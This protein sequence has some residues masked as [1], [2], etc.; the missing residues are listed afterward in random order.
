M[1]D[2][3]VRVEA[4][5]LSLVKPLVE[6][7]K[8]QA[9]KDLHDEL[10]DLLEKTR[11]VLVRTDYLEPFHE[12]FPLSRTQMSEVRVSP[13]RSVGSVS[14]TNDLSVVPSE[15]EVALDR[16]DVSSCDVLFEEEMIPAPTPQ[17]YRPPPIPSFDSTKLL[18]VEENWPEA[19][20]AMDDVDMMSTWQT[21]VELELHEAKEIEVDL[22][23]CEDEIV[24]QPSGKVYR[25]PPNWPEERTTSPVAFDECMLELKDLET[26]ALLQ[27]EVDGAVLEKAVAVEE[28]IYMVEEE[29]F[30]VEARVDLRQWMKT[31]T[32]AEERWISSFYDENVLLKPIQSDV[33]RLTLEPQDHVESPLSHAKVEEC[34]LYYY[35]EESYCVDVVCDVRQLLQQTQL[36]EHSS[37]QFS[38]E[39][40]HFPE[41]VLAKPEW[42]V[43]E[44]GAQPS[45]IK[46]TQVDIAAK[47]R[48]SE[49]LVLPQITVE[50]VE[51]TSGLSPLPDDVTATSSSE[52]SALGTALVDECTI[53]TH[54]EEM[55]SESTLE[56]TTT[57]EQTR[58]TFQQQESRFDQRPE[59][60]EEEIFAEMVVEQKSGFEA[61]EEE[62]FEEMVVEEK[63]GFESQKEE[64]FEEVIVD[65]KKGLESEARRHLEVPEDDV[66]MYSSGEETFDSW[67]VETYRMYVETRKVEADVTF[68]RKQLQQLQQQL[69]QQQ[70]LVDA[71]HGMFVKQMS[72][73]CSTNSHVGLDI[74]CTIQLGH[75]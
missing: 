43:S 12:P 17:V 22:R 55:F 20:S 31:M 15:V 26:A 45:V 33:D 10:D 63:S 44:T 59:A 57:Y 75:R 51:A 46:P 36:V 13:S 6:T 32:Q 11:S 72:E 37:T 4:A 70:Q 7:V 50:H 3:A 1:L 47:K 29:E 60:E 27:M 39:E 56:E 67:T 28:D 40:H 24:P 52:P 30:V 23:E 66:E 16:A 2:Q 62:I 25:P 68:S 61:Q 53:Y 9:T 65:E 58:D 71:S 41:I 34:D 38:V 18:I 19:E 54:D 49:T 21:I 8:I 48:S 64:I 14:P 73:L 74:C 42:S 69:Q 35:E 5:R